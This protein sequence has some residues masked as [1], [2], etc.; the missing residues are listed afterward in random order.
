[1][2]R[3]GPSTL[4]GEVGVRNFPALDSYFHAVGPVFPYLLISF[5]DDRNLH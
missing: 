5:K 3:Q 1:M 2:G 4:E